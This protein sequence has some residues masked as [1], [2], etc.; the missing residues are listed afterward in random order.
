MLKKVAQTAESL[1]KAHAELE[2]KEQPGRAPAPSASG[3]DL[4]KEILPMPH[5]PVSLVLEQLAKMKPVGSP[6]SFVEDTVM[7][8]ARELQKN[9]L[10]PHQYSQFAQMEDALPDLIRRLGG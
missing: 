4:R 9:A 5:K 2:A 3:G 10:P 6:T 8:W 7:E 1:H